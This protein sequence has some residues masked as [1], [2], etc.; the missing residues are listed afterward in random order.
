MSSPLSRSGRTA[1]SQPGRT[2]GGIRCRWGRGDDPT[3]TFLVAQPAFF[4]AV[5]FGAFGFR[6][7]GAAVF[8]GAAFFEL[9]W[10][11]GLSLFRGCP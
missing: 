7:F 2:E 1:C 10:L 11:I 8:F 3:G 6:A 4:V 5:F 9:V